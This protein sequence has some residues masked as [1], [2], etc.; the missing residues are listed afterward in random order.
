MERVV[1]R[2]SG[3]RTRRTFRHW[4][5]GEEV[6]PLF[7]RRALQCGQSVALALVVLGVRNLW[8]PPK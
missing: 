2:G 5:Q 7:D 3:L 8:N 4:A 1:V 6:A